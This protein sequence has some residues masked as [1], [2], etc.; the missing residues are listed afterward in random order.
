MADSNKQSKWSDFFFYALPVVSPGLT[1]LCTTQI[2]GKEGAGKILLIVSAVISAMLAP[3]LSMVAQRR[4]RQ[5]E[6]IKFEAAMSAV[7]DHMGTL[8]SGP[9][10][11]R[12]I[13]RQIHDRL[14]TTLA[15][16]ASPRARAA[17]YSLDEAGALKREVVY[18]N[19]TPPERFDTKTE[20]DLLH[21][22]RRGTVVY[23]PDNRNT[24]GNLQINL[25]N[26]YQSAIVAPA[27]AGSE[28]QGVLIIDAP[29]A[30][31]L[32]K[33][34]ESYVLVIAHMVGTATRLGGK[35]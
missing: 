10:D 35:A 32:S 27:C 8:T 12:A 34:R 24:N 30:G 15:K 6:G 23:I 17:F 5:V 11:A 13:L 18:G 26:D 25:G 4:Y 2:G 29:K 3:L 1:V 19:A 22:I 28:P 33:V 16:D 21:A 20:E 31:E 14:V 9:D 7:I